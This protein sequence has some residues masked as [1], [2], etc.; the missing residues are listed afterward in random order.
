MYSA[1][2]SYC[3]IRPFKNVLIGHAHSFD[4]VIIDGNVDVQKFTAYFVKW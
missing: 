2:W 1:V 3:L 4:D